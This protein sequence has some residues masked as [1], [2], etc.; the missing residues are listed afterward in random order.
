VEIAITDPE[1]NDPQKFLDVIGTLPE[2]NRDIKNRIHEI[3]HT[4]KSKSEPKVNRI[5]GII[6]LKCTKISLFISLGAVYCIHYYLGGTGTEVSLAV[7]FIS[8]LRI[9][10]ICFD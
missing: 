2:A 10:L 6:Y 7:V 9:Q 1:R 4:R 3:S 8:Q 5:K